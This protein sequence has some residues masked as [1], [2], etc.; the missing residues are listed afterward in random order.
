MPLQVDGMNVLA[1]REA[2]K[3]AMT[4]ARTEGPIMMEV[5]HHRNRV[6]RSCLEKRRDHTSAGCQDL[7]ELT[8][9]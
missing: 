6:P 8:R 4:V 2:V 9:V 3:V 7:A 1:V 5:S